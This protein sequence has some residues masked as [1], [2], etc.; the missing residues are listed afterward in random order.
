MSKRTQRRYS[1]EFKVDA[2]KL[3]EDQGYS[4]PEASRRLGIDRSVLARWRRQASE[5]PAG[6]SKP[7]REDEHETELRQLREEVRKLRI[8]RIY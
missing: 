6:S 8:E 5:L 3:V 4:V 7:D 2:V 1:E